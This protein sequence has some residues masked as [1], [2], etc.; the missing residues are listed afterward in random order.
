MQRYIDLIDTEPARQWLVDYFN[1]RLGCSF[2]AE[3]DRSCVV[4]SNKSAAISLEFNGESSFRAESTEDVGELLIDTRY[5]ERPLHANLL[6]PGCSAPAVE[7]CA[8]EKKLVV[9]YDLPGF[10]FYALNRLEEYRDATDCLGRFPFEMS[11]AYCQG[12]LSRPLV[13]EWIL[14][15]AKILQTEFGI[16]MAPQEF[17]ACPTHDVDHI[18]KY[19]KRS[20][21][22]L[23]RG[24]AAEL[25]RGKVLQTLRDVRAIFFKSLKLR[26]KDPYD[27][28]DWLIEKS[29][30]VGTRST[31]FFILGQT[32]CDHDADYAFDD[33]YL[34]SVIRMID[35]RGH[36]IGV[37]PSFLASTDV[38]A[39]QAE[40]ERYHAIRT[41]LLQTNQS[42]VVRMH[43]LRIDVPATYELLS[44]MRL[45]ADHTLGYAGR[46]G[47]RASTC[48]PYRLFSRLTNR[49]LPMRVSPLILME[50][51]LMDQKY[52]ASPTF[53]K[54]QR[55]ILQMRRECENVGGNFNFLWHN[56]SLQTAS[57]RK[58][59]ELAL[60]GDPAS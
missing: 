36:A 11:D 49:T 58:L 4:F 22:K 6:T 29:E 9:N 12:Y 60:F 45:D 5:W 18:G 32:H 30:A 42:A 15:I 27:T 59:Y 26:V 8:D 1:E 21:L 16:T 54:S 20:Y 13:D 55:R 17:T 43:Y 25:K 46:E 57:E 35:T 48:H 40:V 39:L 2:V 52:T 37:H 53:E 31:F 24:A 33:E 34:R 56:S 23:V 14:Y 47:F 10:I 44:N 28:F 3:F 41:T 38:L 50:K 51:T 7:V 19:Y